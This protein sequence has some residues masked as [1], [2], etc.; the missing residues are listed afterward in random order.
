VAAGI[1]AASLDGA[2]GGLAALAGTLGVVGLVVLAIAL[3][4]GWPG[5][6]GVA[7][8]LLAAGYLGHVLVAGETDV[9]ILAVI[10][11]AL[12][13]VG[14]LGQWSLDRRLWG[15]H[16]RSLVISRA[17]GIGVLCALGGGVSFLAILATG[18]PM[19]GGIGLQA[20]AIVA[21]IVLLAL[22]ASVA[23]RTD[24]NGE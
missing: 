15:R 12:L 8:A 23:R 10:S 24:V 16:D 17:V 3:V 1:V 5:G 6:L 9:V 19:P 7:V 2:S 13:L 18:V 11:V 14:E 21:A 22:V 4:I 20:A